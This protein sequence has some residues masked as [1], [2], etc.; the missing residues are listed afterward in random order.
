M[1][2]NNAIDVARYVV[3]K[4]WNSGLLTTNLKLQKILYYIQGYSFKFCNE[5]AFPEAIYKWPYGPVV[6]EVYFEYSHLG[7]KV[8][9]GLSDDL[10]NSV[11]DCIK[12]NKELK[13][14]LDKVIN[15]SY[16]LNA[17]TMVGMT[18]KE[19]PWKNAQDSGIIST[20]SIRLYFDENDPLH[21]GG[22]A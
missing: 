16:E 3:L 11:M 21:I 4:Y 22:V 14:V 2:Y 15:G 6:P 12:C 1:G 10:S 13:S 18:H 19:D 17:T 7:A 9:P 5:A 20:T 8:I